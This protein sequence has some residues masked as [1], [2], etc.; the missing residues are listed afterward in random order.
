MQFID[1]IDMFKLCI[2]RAPVEH[3]ADAKDCTADNHGILSFQETKHAENYDDGIC[4][5]ALVVAQ[6]LREFIAA[7][8]P[9][10][11]Y[12]TITPRPYH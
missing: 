2:V 10:L 8:N 4:C 12:A 3:Q 5:I 9:G 6:L 1:I 11:I 7:A